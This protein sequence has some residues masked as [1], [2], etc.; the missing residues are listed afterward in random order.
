VYGV[1]YSFK[2]GSGD[3]EYPYAGP[4]NVNGTLYGT[5]YGGRLALRRAASIA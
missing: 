2:G 4:V 5:T 1:L 3:C